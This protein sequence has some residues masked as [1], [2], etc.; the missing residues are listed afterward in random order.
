MKTLYKS[1]WAAIVTTAGSLMLAGL[2]LGPLTASA[3]AVPTCVYTFLDDRGFTDHLLVHNQC[4]DRQRI[5][6][7]LAR[8][9]DKPC[10]T[11][12]NGEVINYS[13]R[14]PGRFDKL[15]SC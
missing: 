8:A 4:R 14:Y 5:K 9:T 2:S 15:V 12:N 6:V 1:R 3:A 13:W 10:K 7:V 11:L